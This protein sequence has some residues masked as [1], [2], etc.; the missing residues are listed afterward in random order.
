[1]M[2]RKKEEKSPDDFWREFEKKT[3]EKVLA[4]GLGKYIRGWDAFDEKNHGEL[5][6]LVI[7][8]SGGFHFHHFPRNSWFDAMTRFAGSD[9][10]QEKTFFIPNEKITASDII[11]EEK[12]YKRIFLS[13]PPRLV[14]RYNDES[15]NEKQ[16]L[17][18]A[19]YSP[20]K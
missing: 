16:I 20:A 7:K 1:M 15:G 6:G 9:P 12:W 17:F 4:R 2:W 13:S 10:P 3:G 11:K 19:E 8:T 18:E 14:V 5:W